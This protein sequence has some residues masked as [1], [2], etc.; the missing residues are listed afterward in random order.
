MRAL[1]FKACLIGAALTASAASAQT[2]DTVTLKS[3]DGFTQLRGEIIEFDGKTFSI[4]TGLGVIQVNALQVECEGEA[5]PQ[6]LMFGAEFGIYG[7]NTVGAALMP[8]LIQG[9]ADKLNAD[10]VQDLSSVA[11]ERVLRIIHENGKEMAAIDLRA[12]GSSTGSEGLSEGAATI[13][14][15]SRQ[16][17]DQEAAVL[18]RAGFTDPR[19]TEN[20]HIL[21]LDGLIVITHP[22]NPLNSIELDELAYVFSGDVTNW[23]ELG[24]PDLP[25]VV[26]SANQASGSFDTFNTL[27]LDAAGENLSRAALQFEGNE[28]LSDAVS[29]TPGAIGFT[30]AAYARASKVLNLRQGC[31]IISTPSTFSMKTE[32]YPLSRRLYLYDTPADAPAHSRQLLEYALADEA[33]GI[34]EE[35]GFVSL[36]EE[37]VTLESQGMRLVHAIVGEPEFSLTDMREMLTELKEAERLSLT[38]RF[39]Q[40]STILDPRS[41]RDAVLLGQGLSEGRYAGKEILL[42]GF[43]DSIGEATINRGLSLRRANE[44]FARLGDVIGPVTLSQLPVRTLGYG[45]IAPVGCNTTFEGRQNNRRVE[46]WIRDLR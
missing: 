30:G 37:R 33:Q 32:E 44:V 12:R 42:V 9:Y 26:H 4:K 36:R 18:R 39:T 28:E 24:G 19:D 11:N 16:M 3:F 6:N 2:S 29:R 27:V 25:I 13:G 21:A 45:E 38:F 17:K 7:S 41:A 31:G 46:V 23:S 35:A 14:M 15:T 8:A 34:V 43:T 22:G 40:G 5:C 20:E 1:S 10:L